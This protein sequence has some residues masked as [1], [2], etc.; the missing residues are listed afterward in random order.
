M[1][2]APTAVF[3]VLNTASLLLLVLCGRVVPPLA[4][5]AFQGDNVSHVN[6]STLIGVW[7]GSGVQIFSPPLELAIGIEPMTSSLPRK[8]STN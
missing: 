2:A 7:R 4:V 6:L 3:L 8:C 5:G 1:L